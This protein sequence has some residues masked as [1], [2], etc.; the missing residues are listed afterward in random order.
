MTVVLPDPLGRGRQRVPV[1]CESPYSRSRG[2]PRKSLWCLVIAELYI[3][4][5][6]PQPYHGCLIL[7]RAS[8]F[9]YP[10]GTRIVQAEVNDPPGKANMMPG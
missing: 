1:G 5:I 3:T 6:I 4:V 10:T 8:M 2:L 7:S 9:E